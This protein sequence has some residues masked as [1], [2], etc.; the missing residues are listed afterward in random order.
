MML[1]IIIPTY[2]ERE[3]LAPLVSRLEKAL[4]AGHEIIIVDDNSPDGTAE[5]ALALSRDHPSL[6][7]VRREGKKGLTSAVLAGAE[8]AKGDSILVMDADL[9]HP[10]EAAQALASALETSD[11]V[12]GS[13]LMEGGGVEKWPLH[14]KLISKGADLL[15]RLVLGIRCSDPLS[16]FFAMKRGLLSGTRFRTKG[17]KLLLNILYDNR[18]VRVVEVPYVFRDRFAGRTKLGAL[19]MLNF[20]FDLLRIRFG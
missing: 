4:G 12:I 6:R 14:R 2:N 11:L 5:E 19:E 8:A 3:N 16:G 1:S 17:Y 10:P 7:L 15:A 20:L 9:S 13:R 18:S